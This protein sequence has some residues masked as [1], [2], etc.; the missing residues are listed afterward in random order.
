MAVSNVVVALFSTSAG[1]STSSETVT[2]EAS[3]SNRPADTTTKPSASA[4]ETITGFQVSSWPAAR[5][6][7]LRSSAMPMNEHTNVWTPGVKSSRYAPSRSV[8]TVADPLVT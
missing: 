5:V 3:C 2:S 7:S 6:N 1:W 4:A 8:A